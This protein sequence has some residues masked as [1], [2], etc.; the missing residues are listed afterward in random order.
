M[1]WWSRFEMVSKGRSYR[2]ADRIERVSDLTI[3]HGF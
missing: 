3:G 1:E 2:V